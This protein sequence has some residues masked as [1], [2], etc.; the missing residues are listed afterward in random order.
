[1]RFRF[2]YPIL[3]FLLFLIPFLAYILVGKHQSEPTFVAISGVASF[4]FGLLATNT[5]NGRH[6]RLDQVVAN[7]STERGELTFISESL[8]VF[9]DEREEVLGYIDNYV[10]AELDL[11]VKYFHETDK[12]FLELFDRITALKINNEKQKE[13]YSRLMMALEKIEDTRKYSAT[14]FEDRMTKS[15]WMILYFLIAVIY[16]TLLFADTGGLFAVSIIL[17]LAAIISYILIVTIKLD[18][19]EWKVDEKIFEPYA[20]MLDTI[21]LIRYYPKQIF[22]DRTIKRVFK[23]PKGSKFRIGDLPNYPS[24]EKRVIDVRTIK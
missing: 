14:L 24:L 21:G 15:E 19:M 11:E 4:L 13:I 10:M 12:Q 5:L 17:L 3:F 8:K 22:D 1:M 6:S 23:L 7:G 2:I 16:I 18:R 9:P 20:Q